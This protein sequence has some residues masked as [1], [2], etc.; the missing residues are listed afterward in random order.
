MRICPGLAS[1]QSR[2]ATLDTVPNGGVGEASLEA[3]G[4]KR[5][6]SVR[7]PNAEPNLMVR[8]KLVLLDTKFPRQ[9]FYFAKL[10]FPFSNRDAVFTPRFFGKYHELPH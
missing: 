10:V 7:Y 2:K 1:S 9:I 3:D 6:K 8:P 5:G 4:A